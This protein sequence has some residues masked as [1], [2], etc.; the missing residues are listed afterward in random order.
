M[1][2]LSLR[3]VARHF[4]ACKRCALNSTTPSSVESPGGIFPLMDFSRTHLLLLRGGRGALMLALRVH[5][6][7]LEPLE[8]LAHRSHARRK[9]VYLLASRLTTSPHHTSVRPQWASTRSVSGRRVRAE[10]ELGEE[11]VAAVL[12]APSSLTVCAP[13]PPRTPPWTLA[14]ASQPG[15]SSGLVLSPGVYVGRFCSDRCR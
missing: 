7:R 12:H 6:R 13:P 11:T 3:S 14:A 4:R 9:T 10:F 8:P 2:F 1:S 15:A 5:L